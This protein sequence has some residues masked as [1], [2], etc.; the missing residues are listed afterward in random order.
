MI[1][2][3]VCEPEMPVHESVVLPETVQLE[4]F[5]TFQ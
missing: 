5:E 4:T 2:L 3:V 1:A